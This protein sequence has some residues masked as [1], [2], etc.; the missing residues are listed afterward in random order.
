MHLCVCGHYVNALS[1]KV[2]MWHIHLCITGWTYTNVCA[3]A[4]QSQLMMKN[5]CQ[6]LLYAGAVGAGQEGTPL[7]VTPGRAICGTQKVLE[8]SRRQAATPDITLLLQGRYRMC[9]M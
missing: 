9:R 2:G 8:V 6:L 3:T 4:W 5:N 7:N 1:A